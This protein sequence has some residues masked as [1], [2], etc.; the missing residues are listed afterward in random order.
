[1]DQHENSPFLYSPIGLLLADALLLLEP[2]HCDLIIHFWC[3][4]PFTNAS[5]WLRSTFILVLNSDH[6]QKNNLQILGVD[7]ALMTQRCW[8]A[9]TTPAE[10]Q[11][12]LTESSIALSPWARATWLTHTYASIRGEHSTVTG[13]S[14]FL[15]VSFVAVTLALAL[16]AMF[17]RVHVLQLQR[18]SL[19]SFVH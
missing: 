13:A 3:T 6:Q 9:R 11:R 7:S 5:N 17:L 8:R 14:P 16:P 1:M 12:P 4:P 2:I 15:N 10:F 19:L 18:A